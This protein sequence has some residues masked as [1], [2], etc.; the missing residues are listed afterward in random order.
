MKTL[1]DLDQ[2]FDLLPC[3]FCG[4]EAHFNSTVTT[5]KTTIKLNKA[6]TFYGV[7]CS[8]CSHGSRF[9]A[10]D[11]SVMAESWNRRVQ[12]PNR[13]LTGGEA[14]RSD[15]VVGRLSITAQ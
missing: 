13:K 4:G 5:C 2:E 7:S 9:G 12:R 3:P 14:L 8:T 10:A 6:D 11:P 15:A 1:N